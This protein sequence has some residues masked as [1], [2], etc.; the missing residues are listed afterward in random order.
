VMAG[1]DEVPVLSPES[2]VRDLAVEMSRFPTGLAIIREETGDLAGVVSDGDLRRALITI[3]DLTRASVSQ[4]ITK[5]PTTIGP[6]AL[7]VHALAVMEGHHPRPISALP[8]IDDGSVVGL[9]TIHQI[10]KE[11]PS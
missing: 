11:T 7:L 5:N 10:H 8:V 2:S 6:D 4:V 9:I 1:L 3:D